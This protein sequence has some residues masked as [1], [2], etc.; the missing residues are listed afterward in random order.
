MRIP[1]SSAL[2]LQGS[3]VDGADLSGEIGT[4]LRRA[5]L[6]KEKMPA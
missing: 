4:R 1:G 2:H 3:G 5:A 6:E